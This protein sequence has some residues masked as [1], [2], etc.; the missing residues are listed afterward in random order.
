M[1][2]LEVGGRR[3]PIEA[4]ELAIG[5]DPEGQIVLTGVTVA[6]RHAFIRA[7]P[8]GQVSIHKAD[9]TVEVL[10]NGV[11]MG[12]QPTPLL[13]GDKVVIGG[14]ELRFGDERRS[15][16]TQ[17]MKVDEAAFAAPAGSSPGSGQRAEGGR[18][19]SLTDGREY[20]I[21]GGSLVIGRS[22]ECDVVLTSRNVSR[23]HAEII[24][25]PKGYLLVDSSTNGTFVNG[26]RI[27]GQRSLKRGD[28]IRCGDDEFR[29]YADASTE[30][31]EE[32]ASE[33]VVEFS[34]PAE[35]EESDLLLPDPSKARGEGRAAELAPSPPSP[36]PAGHQLRDTL[37]G[38]PGVKVPGIT[39]GSPPETGPPPSPPEPPRPAAPREPS[40]AVPLKALAHLV[41]RSGDLKG[42]RFSIRVPVANIGRA[43]YNDV[44][45]PDESVSTSHAKLQRREGIWVLVDLD[46]TNG[47]SVDGERITGEAP[48]APGAKIQ[49]GDIEVF[50]EPT[51]DAAEVERG[52]G[53]KVIGAFQMP[54][55]PPTRDI[56]R[57]P[58]PEPLAL[59]D[60]TPQRAE[61]PAA[62]ERRQR[63]EP[64]LAD[65]LPTPPGSITPVTTSNAA[66]EPADAGS[67]QAITRIIW[68]L[69]VL[70]VLAVLIIVFAG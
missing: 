29:F 66:E 7:T 41:V 45:I 8:D 69:L 57:P 13:H 52:G 22:T 59:A 33:T 6:P 24:Q 31:V 67:S 65:E 42:K 25:S 9:D 21:G 62:V 20:A 39:R 14:H 46:S 17:F 47:T 5:S 60:E 11:R 55:E 18:L 38:V 68:G 44:I 2:Y 54:D 70:V 27:Q 26:E 49:F 53:T 64:D 56:P 32:A 36:P 28:V 51:D 40:E 37:F 4:G 58:A 10:V 50:F 1:S 61:P 19:V 3:H 12:A 35:V 43:D 30:G 16:S 15:G 34:P 23:R 63:G 48:L